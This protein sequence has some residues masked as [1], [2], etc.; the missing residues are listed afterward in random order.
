MSNSTSTR[1]LRKSAAARR[2][3]LTVY[4]G[5]QAVIRENREL[6]LGE[7]K[8]AVQLDG[9]P[10]A[11]VENSLVVLGAKGPGQFKIGPTSYEPANMSGASI[12]QKSIGKPVTLIEPT[13]QG[14]VRNSGTL[15][16]VLGNQAAIQQNNTIVVV[17]LSPKFEVEDIPDGLAN[18]PSI[19]FEPSVTE[20]GVY[21]VR[22]LYEAENIN[23]AAR[24]NAFFDPATSTLTRFECVVDLT[25]QSGLAIEDGTFKLLTG[26]NYGTRRTY[27]RGM[28]AQAAPASMA[29]LGGGA[30][31]ESVMA[32]DAAVETV[33]EQKLFV[34]PDTLSIGPT[35]SKNCNLFLAE[36][37][38]VEVELYL[39]ADYNSYY[40]SAL[41]DVD[42]PKF[43]VLVRL[44]IKNDRE[45]NLGK[46]MPGGEVAFFVLD[47]AGS[48]QKVDGATM[49]ARAVGEAF[50]L[51]LRKPSAD[52]KATRRLSFVHQ[53]EPDLEPE[54]PV[55]PE[56]GLPDEGDVRRGPNVT[57]SMSP[58]VMRPPTIASAPE[59][60]GKEKKP[61]KPLFREEEREVTIH[62][63]KDTA[64]EVLV[65][66][67]FPQNAE[68][69]KRPEFVDSNQTSGVVRVT[70][71]AK[72]KHVVSYRIKYRIN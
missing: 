59:G 26:G 72:G 8:N 27:A 22:F 14:P 21:Q 61:V 53:D 6:D 44:R 49:T 68:F 40:G 24:Y 57:M 16:Y 10:T 9:L 2:I 32:D 29:A 51:D 71:P 1:E 3:E 37:V 43:P 12:L 36:G 30:H 62:N 7:G 58:A 65:S 42:A 15:L 52:V 28:R 33:G 39:P 64:V 25:N 46:D 23:W 66:E 18:T 34:L 20:G 31:T 55:T 60:N 48:E 35:A 13:P 38:P 5:G 4:Q 50:K 17:P 67:A 70:V 45:S 41:R 47:S 56:G 54:S 69:I 19:V 11:F 63:Y